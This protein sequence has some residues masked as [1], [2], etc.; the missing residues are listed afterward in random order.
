[1]AKRRAN[2][3]GNIRKR[4]DGRWE[5]RY[6]AGHDP[7]TG[8]QIFKNVLGKSQAEV[9]EKLTA[10]IQETAGLDILKAEQYTVETWLQFWLDNF[11][12]MT[13][14]PSTFESYSGNL[15]VHIKPNIGGIKLTKLRTSDL[16][17][18][19]SK[20]L[21]EGR[22][23]R[24]ESEKQPKGLSP[25]TV[26]N[27]HI[28][29]STAL[30]KAVAE[31][32]IPYN[33]AKACTL[34]KGEHVEMK[35]LPLDKIA[36]FFAE[37]KNSGVYE[38][39]LLEIATGLRRG[40]L[41]GLKWTDVNYDAGTI[42]I[43][44]QICRI[45]GVVTEGPLKTKN[46]YRKIVVPADVMQVLKDKQKKDNGASEYVFFSPLTNGPI[47]PDSVLHMLHRVLD[48]AG[49]PRIR[50][51]DLR[52]T[53]ATMALQNGVDVKTLSNILGHF[54]A[55]FT[56]DTYAHVTTGMQQDA[57]NKVGDFLKGNI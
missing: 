20:L 39:Y 6:T 45:N 24:K 56:L 8:K 42:Y 32:L 1:M 41:L 47:S 34:P 57:A 7:V 17:K 44:R 51:H 12:K 49:L 16:Q 54:S 31:K 2:G 48:R 29:I 10:A 28:F 21:T 5:G 27:V 14:R 40:E 37:A 53:F 30:D 3:E 25:K 26:R 55:G 43:Q 9:K 11:G 13:M 36:A 50:F 38:M 33:P 15:R 46:S 52:H 22:V 18:F 23:V 35:T 4:A 19:Y